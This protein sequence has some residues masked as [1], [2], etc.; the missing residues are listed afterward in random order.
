[1]AGQRR[2]APISAAR[3]RRQMR[4]RR[5]V[6]VL[7][8]MALITVVALALARRGDD[9]EAVAAP[10]AP[11]SASRPDAPKTP[12]PEP[13]PTNDINAPVTGT[14]NLEP[15]MTAAFDRAE[16]AARADGVVIEIYAGWRSAEWQQILFDRAVKKYGSEEAAREW[17]LPPEKSAHVKGI[18]IDVRPRAAGTWLEGHGAAYGLCRLY[19]NEWW[20]FELVQTGTCPPRQ[21]SAAG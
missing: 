7:V 1:M 11:S 13:S 3:R 14:T 19:D 16:K 15:E 6:T 12:A 21:P 2:A 9:G 8:S 18:A 4:L 17:V 20:H 5:T 10:A